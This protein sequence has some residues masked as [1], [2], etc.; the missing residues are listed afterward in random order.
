MSHVIERSK[1]VTQVQLSAQHSPI[2]ALPTSSL[3]N[4][5]TF[6]LIQVF[7]HSPLTYYP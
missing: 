3:L 4:F 6:L 5:M 7:V 1:K 2:P